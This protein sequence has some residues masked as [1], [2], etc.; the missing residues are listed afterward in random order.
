MLCTRRAKG[1]EEESGW[2][3]PANRQADAARG[4]SK[5]D[6]QRLA[7]DRVRIIFPHK[8][9]NMDIN[10]F[11]LSSITPRKWIKH[12]PYCE[13]R[14]PMEQSLERHFLDQLDGVFKVGPWRL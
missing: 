3:V 7:T 2:M 12:R 5:P 13:I 1:C 14:A 9:A 10:V 11:R 6:L 4:F 8:L